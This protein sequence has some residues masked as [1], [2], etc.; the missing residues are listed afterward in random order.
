MV[1]FKR[2]GSVQLP[3]LLHADVWCCCEEA[4]TV[5]CCC[6]SKMRFCS[7]VLVR[8]LWHYSVPN[9][10]QLYPLVDPSTTIDP[11]GR[12]SQ[13]RYN[14]PLPIPQGLHGHTCTHNIQ[15]WAR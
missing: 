4:A 1:L 2:S 13:Y 6:L 7:I 15:D 11:Q 12:R 3:S 5:R 9:I 10:K 14:Q 8:T